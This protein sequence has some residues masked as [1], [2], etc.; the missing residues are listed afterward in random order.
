MSSLKELRE[1]GAF[2]PDELVQKEI[3]FKLGGGDEAAEHT[4]T[5]FIRRLSIGSQEEIFLGGGDAERS[6]SAKMIAE[7]V[8]L[9]E[10]GVE[11]ITF[12]DAYRLEPAIA[13]AMIQAVSEVNKSTRGN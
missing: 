9:G 13:L 7:T 11:K 6:R 2:V 4:V 5:V 3:T 12:V 10:G 8:R 1:L